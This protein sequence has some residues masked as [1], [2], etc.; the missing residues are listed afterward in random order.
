MTS[1]NVGVN[2]VIKPVNPQ[3]TVIDGT[4]STGQTID[5]GGAGYQIALWAVY[6]HIIGSNTSYLVQ[7]DAI[8]YSGFGGQRYDSVRNNYGRFPI[9][10]PEGADLIIT[11][12]EGTGGITGLVI[13][14]RIPSIE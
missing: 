4:L 9:L 14:E 1:V 7:G 11:R 12:D 13:H 2:G 6:G 5:T 8:T 10:L 3:L